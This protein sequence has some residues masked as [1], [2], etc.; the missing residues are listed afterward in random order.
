MVDIDELVGY[1]IIDIPAEGAKNII[2]RAGDFLIGPFFAFLCQNSIVQKKSDHATKP[3]TS[4]AGIA[5]RSA[6][7]GVP[8]PSGHSGTGT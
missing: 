3:A 7:R 6:G 5:C 8:V 1:V 2:F 4:V